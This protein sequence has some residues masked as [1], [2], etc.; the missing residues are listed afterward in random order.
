[1][2]PDALILRVNVARAEAGE[3]FD[4]A[5]AANLSA[6]A[7]PRLLS[8]LDRLDVAERCR[9]AEIL[10]SRWD[11]A[12]EHDWRSW[13]AARLRADREVK[14]WRPTLEALNCPKPQEEVVGPGVTERGDRNGPGSPPR[15]PRV[16]PPG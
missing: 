12:H 6:D 14:R 4:A 5:Y 9:A 15:S 8:S 13:N 7:V 16:H 11:H 1:M 2:N 10:L 3:G